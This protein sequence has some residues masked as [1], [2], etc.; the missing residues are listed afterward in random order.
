MEEQSKPS[1]TFALEPIG[2]SGDMTDKLGLLHSLTLLER[3]QR[4]G[5][6]TLSGAH[7]RG[8]RLRLKKYPVC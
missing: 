4:T 2:S 6:H 8:K 3:K 1:L 5:M 7:L